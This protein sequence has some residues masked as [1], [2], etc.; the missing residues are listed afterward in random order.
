MVLFFYSLLLN[1]NN[2]HKNS[3]Y[4]QPSKWAADIWRNFNVENVIKIKDSHDDHDHDI[5]SNKR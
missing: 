4:I 3:I 5:R 1:I 2:I